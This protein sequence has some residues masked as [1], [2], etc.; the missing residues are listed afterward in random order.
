M[1]YWLVKTEP[2]AYSID[3]LKRDKKTAWD[4][5]RN[6]QARNFMR[7]QMHAGD[8]V[9]IYHSSTDIPAIVGLG[10]VCS[11]AHPDPTQFDAKSKYYEP[12]AS[13]EKP[14]WML[15]DIC[16]KKKFKKPIALAEL[17]ESGEFK[18]MMLTQRGSRLSV[19]PVG[20][21]EYQAI[22]SLAS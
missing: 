9:F 5:V 13:R 20:E 16:F 6:F 15:V 3:D 1:N 7:D 18:N 22:L 4:G 17:K 19:Q 8:P 12:R 2:S 14:V 11:E 10:E 21:K